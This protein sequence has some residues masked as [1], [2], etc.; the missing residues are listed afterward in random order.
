[1]PALFWSAQAPLILGF[2]SLLQKQ[3]HQFGLA[4]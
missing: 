2:A 4:T 1:M 3:P